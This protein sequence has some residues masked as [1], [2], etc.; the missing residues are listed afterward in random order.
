MLRNMLQHFGN[1]DV[2]I[3]YICPDGYNLGGWIANQRGNHNTP[4][5]YHYLTSEQSERLEKL[6]IVWNPTKEKWL[7]G[8]QHAYE[9]A[10]LLNG[11]KW[12]TT[13]ISPDGYQTGQ[14]LRSQK[15]RSMRNQLDDEKAGMLAEIGF[16]FA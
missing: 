4:T 7:E 5:Q 11:S 13:Y 12:L 9:Y 16:V 3:S 8:F 10:K 2:P 15:R 1:L 6:G 14:W